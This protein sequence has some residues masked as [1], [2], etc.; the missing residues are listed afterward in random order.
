MTT[1]ATRASCAGT[2]S[3]MPQRCRVRFYCLLPCY[4]TSEYPGSG[5]DFVKKAELSAAVVW[6]GGQALN[7]REFLFAAVPEEAS[8]FEVLF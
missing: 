6:R 7:A 1:K 8:R 5:G 4:R 2:L 3:Q